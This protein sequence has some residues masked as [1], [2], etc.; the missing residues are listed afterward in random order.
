MLT[1]PEP[2]EPLPTRLLVPARIPLPIWGRVPGWMPPGPMPGRIV[3]PDR[4]D[5]RPLEP[6]VRLLDPMTRDGLRFSVP[7]FWIPLGMRDGMRLRDTPPPDI[8]RPENPP[9]GTLLTPPPTRPPPMR[10]R[11]RS[12]GV[13][14]VAAAA[15]AHR[16]TNWYLMVHSVAH[17]CW[18]TRVRREH[19]Q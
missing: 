14:H 7:R 12:S 3:T 18:L 10:P 5:P 15:S 19:L 1:R 16:A 17:G 4:F 9:R 11:A 2:S 13:R 8:P 6:G